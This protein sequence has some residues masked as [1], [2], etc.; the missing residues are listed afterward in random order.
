MK[1]FY[2]EFILSTYDKLGEFIRMAQK[3]QHKKHIYLFGCGG[4]G[5][6]TL[7]V[8]L[9]HGIKPYAFSA[10]DKNA[11]GSEISGLSV[12]SYDEMI[13]DPDK[14]I[15]ISTLT[16]KYIDEMKEQ[17]EESGVFDY[18]LVFGFALCDRR[19]RDLSVFAEHLSDLEKTYNLL[20]D[21]YSRSAF[22]ALVNGKINTS[23]I[24]NRALLSDKPLFLDDILSLGED[25]IYFDGG[26][27]TGDNACR[28]L[29]K[30]PNGTVYSFEP[31]PESFGKLRNR[32]ENDSRVAPINKGL[33]DINN[34]ITFTVRGAP[35]SGLFDQVLSVNPDEKTVDVEIV[36]LDDYIDKKPTFITMD[37]EGAEMGALR[38][39]SEIIKTLKPKMVIALYHN[40]SDF[41]EVPS[42]I[43]SLRPD[44]KFYVRTTLLSS[45]GCHGYFL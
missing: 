3:A 6:L 22:A 4:I 13:A 17:L 43:L 5:S 2:S 24:T 31:D 25:E 44:Y 20:E 39:A 34:T 30:V 23:V 41:W 11:V 36:K 28:F 16:T 38:G 40:A 8:L 14:F 33:G 29:E 10:N 32:F 7:D 37:M 42:F 27:F 21:E 18:H 35:N 26:A 15:I 1:S 9:N 45:E 19:K 12:L